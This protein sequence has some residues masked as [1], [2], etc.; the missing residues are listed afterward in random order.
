MVPTVPAVNPVLVE[1]VKHRAL[2]EWDQVGWGRV[3]LALAE[4]AL[5]LAPTAELALAPVE[6][7][8]VL[9]LVLAEWAPASGLVRVVWVLGCPDPE[10]PVLG[11]PD[12]VATPSEVA[13]P[14][15]IWG[16]WRNSARLASGPA[17]RVTV[18]LP[19]SP[20]RP[21][22]KVKMPVHSR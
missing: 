13:I 3:G 21:K 12:P 16:K 19:S 1:W 9:G 20:A 18:S 7:D 15:A 8:R 17:T 5:Q 14:S 6:W 22:R 11:C 10:C 4:W 2:V